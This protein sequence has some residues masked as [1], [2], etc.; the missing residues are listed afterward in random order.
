MLF[1][2][3]VLPLFKAESY[4]PAPAHAWSCSTS[5]P[6]VPVSPLTQRPTQHWCLAL[7]FK[8]RAGTALVQQELKVSSR[9][10]RAMGQVQPS[11]F[12]GQHMP[13]LRRAQG[14]EEQLL[15]RLGEVRSMAGQWEVS[16]RCNNLNR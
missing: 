14:T 15:P 16:G 2:E 8:G 5:V 12:M 11:A 13:W 3:Q 9:P 4:A 6:G 1:Q 7:V 10:L